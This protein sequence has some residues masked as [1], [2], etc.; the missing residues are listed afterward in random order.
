MVCSL[1]FFEMD[2]WNSASLREKAADY[3]TRLI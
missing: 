1:S 3:N 2:G